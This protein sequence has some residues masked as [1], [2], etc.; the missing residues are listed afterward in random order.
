MNSLWDMRKFAAGFAAI[1][2]RVIF[3]EWSGEQA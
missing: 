1:L 3:Y 2:I